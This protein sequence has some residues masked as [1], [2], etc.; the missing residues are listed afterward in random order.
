MYI[1]YVCVCV[2]VCMSVCINFLQ[3]K[4]KQINI[5]DMIL[6]LSADLIDP[7]RS[8]SIFMDPYKILMNPYI[9]L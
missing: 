9:A 5:L 1:I 6:S 8:L 3:I 7:Y 2:C 4:T